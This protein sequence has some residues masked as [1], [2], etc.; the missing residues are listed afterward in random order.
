M[1]TLLPPPRESVYQL[2]DNLRD[3]AVLLE[4]RP[5]P[6][7]EAEREE[8]LFSKLGAKGWARLHHFRDNVDDKLKD[9]LQISARGND[10]SH[11]G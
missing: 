8:L 5:A 11:L 10:L 4:V 3:E 7:S 1:T 9:F 2:S 6:P